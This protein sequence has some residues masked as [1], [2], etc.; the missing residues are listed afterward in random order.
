M[1][2]QAH[3][4]AQLHL[5]LDSAQDMALRALAVAVA[6]P[7][8]AQV[9]FGRISPRGPVGRGDWILEYR[10]NQSGTWTKP[11]STRL[12]AAKSTYSVIAGFFGMLFNSN[13]KSVMVCDPCT[14]RSSTTME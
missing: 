4:F 13:M 9:E 8:V 12:S 3:E 11:A 6:L 2:D 5:E 10:L 14:K 7:D 1:T